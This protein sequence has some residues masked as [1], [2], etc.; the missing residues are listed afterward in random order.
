M[1]TEQ[2]KTT[3]GKNVGTPYDFRVP[4]G[5]DDNAKLA[6][7]LADGFNGVLADLIEAAT[8]ALN[9]KLWASGSTSIYAPLAVFFDL[10][11]EEGMDQFGAARRACKNLAAALGGEPENY[12]PTLVARLEEARK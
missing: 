10:S 3:R 11:T 5:A 2:R 1:I 4:E 8:Y 6:D 9:G 7:L 12:V